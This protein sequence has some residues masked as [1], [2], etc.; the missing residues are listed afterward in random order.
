MKMRHENIWLIVAAG[1]ATA[2]AISVVEIALSID[3]GNTILAVISAAS[4][5]LFAVCAVT[6]LTIRSRLLKAEKADEEVKCL[7]LKKP[8]IEVRSEEIVPKGKMPRD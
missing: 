8:G 4:L 5:A 3:S 7:R 6:A 2:A 1:S